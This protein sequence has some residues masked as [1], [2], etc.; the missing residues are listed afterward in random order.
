MADNS[1]KKA[2]CNEGK[3]VEIPVFNLNTKK[4]LDA[5]RTRLLE[6]FETNI[7]H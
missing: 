6:R 4:G 5:Y 1:E 2:E 3:P 7:S